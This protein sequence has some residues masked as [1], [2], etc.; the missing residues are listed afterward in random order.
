MIPLIVDEV[1]VESMVL[2]GS[3]IEASGVELDRTTTC[4][5]PTD[6]VVH[7]IRQSGFRFVPKSDGPHVLMSQ[8]E[9]L[10]GREG[11]LLEK[12]RLLAYRG[13][14]HVFDR[15]EARVE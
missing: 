14:S 1:V 6:C 8:I 11:V 15:S 5:P 10:D 2:S 7:S 3:K 9:G 12:D 4:R 13:V